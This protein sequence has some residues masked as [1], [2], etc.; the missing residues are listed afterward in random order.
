MAPHGLNQRL[1]LLSADIPVTVRVQHLD[2]RVQQHTRWRTTATATATAHA[3]VRRVVG[4]VD[5]TLG[6]GTVL[7]VVVVVVVVVGLS[8]RR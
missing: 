5:A 7:G 2:H 1:I 6:V 3:G 4:A 8:I